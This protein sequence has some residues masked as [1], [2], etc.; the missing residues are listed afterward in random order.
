MERILQE[1]L[2]EGFDWERTYLDSPDGLLLLD[3]NHEVIKANNTMLKMLGLDSFEEIRGK[4]CY[5]VVHGTDTPPKECVH[6]KVMHSH[7]VEETE[8]SCNGRIYRVTETPLI[9]KKGNIVGYT[10]SSYDVT[11]Q[12]QADDLIHETK[13]KF[14]TIFNKFPIGI[15]VAN[16]STGEML[17]ANDYFCEMLNYSKKEIMHLTIYDLTHPDDFR[18]SKEHAERA[19]DDNVPYR[20]TKRYVTKFGQV[21]WVYVAV[22]PVTGPG[23]KVSYAFSMVEDI[24]DKVFSQREI[25]RQKDI[26]RSYV[27]LVRVI[28][29][30][31]D[32][33]GR[34]TM[35]NRRGR[36]LLGKTEN[37]LVGKNWF[38]NYVPE[39]ERTQVTDIFGQLMRGELSLNGDPPNYFTNAITAKGDQEKLILW[40]NTLLRDS[41]GKISGVLS[42][43]EDVT[44]DVGRKDLL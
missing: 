15:I 29:V 23:G 10:H 40:H 34:I 24:T 30:S 22:A 41:D 1:L 2:A 20:L 3:H 28:I 43:G 12:K 44:E 14:E 37:E 33:Q 25:D 13:E 11:E 35:I 42:A 26:L 19:N 21:R 7:H 36:E 8:I 4:K 27:D 18:I 5:E 32:A 39:R 9:S 17:D 38:L 31:L 16:L 6:A